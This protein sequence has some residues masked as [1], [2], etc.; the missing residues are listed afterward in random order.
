MVARATQDSLDLGWSEQPP[1]VTA[2]SS[3][4]PAVPLDNS[5]DD[6]PTRVATGRSALVPAAAA[7]I[8]IAS[9]LPE[10]SAALAVPSVVAE[11]FDADDIH[12]EGARVTEPGLAP[13]P[14]TSAE[15]AAA[16]PTAALS[17]AP[18]AA[19]E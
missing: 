12:E 11:A 16:E 1:S 15:I 6:E 5:D 4:Q 8:E 7:D 19:R 2:Q 14:L 3:E 17:E 10:E 13:P 18:A 9:A